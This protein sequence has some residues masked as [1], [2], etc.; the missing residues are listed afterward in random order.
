MMKKNIVLI[1]VFSFLC[2][3]G[4]V[5]C[6]STGGAVE[7]SK[8]TPVENPGAPVEEAAA[9]TD[10]L[11]QEVEPRFDD[12]Q[13]KGFGYDLPSWVD[14]ALDGTISSEFV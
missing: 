7:G 5:S 1:S 9:A 14:S 8:A 4:L 13:Y 12:W 11:V 3:F 6:A 10:L 2:L